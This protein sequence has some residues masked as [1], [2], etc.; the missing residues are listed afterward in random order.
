MQSRLATVLRLTLLLQVEH[1]ASENA[2]RFRM[3]VKRSKSRFTG[4][5][6]PYKRSFISQVSDHPLQVVSR[7]H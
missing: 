5:N 7:S 2:E 4:Q 1:A 3:S 6:N